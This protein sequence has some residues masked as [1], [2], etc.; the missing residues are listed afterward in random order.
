[1][2]RNP[3]CS[4]KVN[5]S[6]IEKGMRLRVKPSER[7]NGYLCPS[8]TK[9]AA[10]TVTVTGKSGPVDRRYTIHTDAG[11]VMPCPGIQTFWKLDEEDQ[12]AGASEEAAFP[13]QASEVESDP[14]GTPK[15]ATYEEHGSPNVLIFKGFEEKAP[16]AAG[17]AVRVQVDPKDGSVQ[18]KTMLSLPAATCPP[19]TKFWALKIGLPTGSDL[20]AAL[21]EQL[22]E[23]AASIKDQEDDEKVPFVVTKADLLA[24]P[25]DSLMDSGADVLT[26]V[27]ITVGQQNCHVGYHR[28]QPVITLTF[29]GGRRMHWCADHYSDADNYRENSQTSIVGSEEMSVCR[30]DGQEIFRNAFTMR[31]DENM[32]NGGLG[33]RA[34]RFDET[35]RCSAGED[36]GPGTTVQHMPAHEQQEITVGDVISG[37]NVTGGGK[38][39]GT[40]SKIRHPRGMGIYGDTKTDLSRQAPWSRRY[41]ITTDSGRT[42]IVECAELQVAELSG[43]NHLAGCKP[44]APGKRVGTCAPGCAWFDSLKVETIGR[45]KLAEY[46]I[47]PDHMEVQGGS[48]RTVEPHPGPYPDNS[49]M[50]PACPTFPDDEER[51][52]VEQEIQDV[53]P[54]AFPRV[55]FA[56]EYE[57]KTVSIIEPV[58]RG[59]GGGFRRGYLWHAVI[60]EFILQPTRPSTYEDMSWVPGLA[61]GGEIV[62]VSSTSAPACAINARRV[63]RKRSSR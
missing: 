57:G 20:D 44:A 56:F 62:A 48:V 19:G 16:S 42:A 61:K 11:D 39:V 4:E 31:R 33:W 30:Y 47:I 59:A 2:A 60:G 7:E 45:E 54:E 18:M 46:Q 25:I 14:T 17:T 12:T 34:E 32:G 43:P 36:A 40:V 63:L 37:R 55:V 3:K 49:A 24:K 15:F 5:A 1:V 26:G 53:D 52:W 58:C 8:A 27:G 10:I 38:A 21:R 9:G 13:E 41:E 22:H 6:K 51:R 50:C 29:A 28:C 35:G 23:D